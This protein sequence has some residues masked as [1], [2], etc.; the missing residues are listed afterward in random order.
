MPDSISSVTVACFFFEWA[1]MMTYGTCTAV[2]VGKF[3]IVLY[4]IVLLSLQPTVLE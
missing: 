3:L 2:L 4:F 1:V